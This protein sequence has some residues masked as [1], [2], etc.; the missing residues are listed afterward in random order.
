MRK[1]SIILAAAVVAMGLA[2]QP[3]SAQSSPPRATCSR[4]A[5]SRKPMPRCPVAPGRARRRRSEPR[6]RSRRC[7]T[8]TGDPTT[9]LFNAINSNDYNSAQD[10]ISRGADLNGQ[11]AL[12]E[13]PIDLSVSLN[14]NSIT[15]MLLAARN[16]SGDDPD[17]T[18]PGPGSATPVAKY[19]S[20][21]A[22]AQSSAAV[23]IKLIENPNAAPGNNPGT[24]NP[25]AGFL[26]FDK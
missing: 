12:G 16:A 26:G 14:R 13:T 1:I 25:S 21:S 22:P 19:S 11:N 5:C 18:G 10:A 17:A 4:P 23:P 15:F 24:P 7:E 3:A 6:S 2:S 9:Q 8:T 20:K